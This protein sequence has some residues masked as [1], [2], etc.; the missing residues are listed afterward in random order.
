MKVQQDSAIAHLINKKNQPAII[1][2]L[3]VMYDMSTTEF[4]FHSAIIWK[5]NCERKSG[6]LLD[7]DDDVYFSETEERFINNVEA[8]YDKNFTATKEKIAIEKEDN[9]KELSRIKRTKK[10]IHLR[11]TGRI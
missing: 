6:F 2:F 3:S 11:F 5:D 7:L 10:E 1:H 9:F 4:H 8:D